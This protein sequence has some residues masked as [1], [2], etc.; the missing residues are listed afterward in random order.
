MKQTKVVTCC[1]CCEKEITLNHSRLFLATI[2]QKN[3]NKA[4]DLCESCT[5]EVLDLLKHKR[6]SF[7]FDDPARQPIPPLPTSP[8]QYNVVLVTGTCSCSFTIEY[9]NG[10]TKLYLHED[11]DGN[12]SWNFS[13]PT[14]TSWTSKDWAWKILSKAP[15]IDVFLDS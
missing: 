11:C 5:K 3:K 13:M 2:F 1:D 15:A 6:I 7:G 4:L 12:L 14:K 8:G 9:T 10:K